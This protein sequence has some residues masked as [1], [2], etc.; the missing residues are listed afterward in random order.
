MQTIG[1]YL[2]KEREARDI[3]LSDVS[4]CTKISKIYLD[5]LEKDE[6]AKI[7]GE[8]YVKGYISS[9]A[10]CVGI[11]EQEALKLYNSSQIETETSNAEKIK[12]EIPQ[13]KKKLTLH[14][15]SFN[16]KIWLVLVS[17]IPIILAIGVYY[18]F[19][20]NQKPAQA[21]KS[22]AEQNRAIQTKI[23]SKVEPNFSQGRQDGNSF[24]SIKQ[25][26]SGE[27]I[28][29][30]EG[31]EQ[32][33]NGISQIPGPLASHQPEKTSK[34]GVPYP[35]AYESSKLK[36]FADSENDQTSFENNLTVI[37]AT[38]C[39]N[40][41]NR[42]PQGAGESFE[43]S[44]EKIYIWT[45]IKCERPPSSIRHIYYFN[46]EKV[47]DILL[48]IRSSHWRTW[49]FKSLS[50]KRYIG[51]WRVDITSIDGKLLQRIEFEII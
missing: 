47:N 18:Y 36:D 30:R 49:S 8:A 44:M 42:I 41:K 34:E 32:H 7:P 37:E 39:S 19:F 28:E 31:G 10:A 23:I 5:C 14:F 6:Y 33:E 16:K 1:N 12:L 9:Y 20:Q 51:S 46:G 22:L 48:K 11:N 4:D 24:P 38:A 21:E 25:N 43:W 3:S 29:N 40:I 26:G 15:L 17:F 27:R 35:P 50:N 13:V 45:E 2:K